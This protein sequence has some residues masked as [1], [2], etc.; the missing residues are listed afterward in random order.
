GETILVQPTALIYRDLTVSMHL[1]LEYPR[2][3]RFSWHPGYDHRNTWLR[4]IGPG[5]VAVQSIFERPESSEAITNHSPA[6]AQRW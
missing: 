3:Q 1:H 5:R 2:F 6:T 4:L